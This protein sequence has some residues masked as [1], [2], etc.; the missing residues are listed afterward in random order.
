M[1][2]VPVSKLWIRRT[3]YNFTKTKCEN[4]SYTFSYTYNIF[5]SGLTYLAVTHIVSVTSY[6][7]FSQGKK[8]A[9]NTSAKTKFQAHHHHHHQLG[10]F[11]EWFQLEDFEASA[12][13]MWLPTKIFKSSLP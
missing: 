12:M 2:E 9:H 11:E 7:Y 10:T 13:A 3:L 1:N 4:T 5:P 8:L 6:H